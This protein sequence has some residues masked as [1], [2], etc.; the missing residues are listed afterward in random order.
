MLICTTNPHKVREFAGL[1]NPL[2][3]DLHPIMNLDIP[4]TGDSF[5]DNAREKAR[6]YALRY[7]GQWLLSEDS[8]LVVPAL[9]GMPGAFSARYADVQVDAGGVLR[10]ENSGRSRVEMDAL[11][12]L[13]LLREA[14]DLPQNN[15]GA[16]FVS[17][18][19]VVDPQGKIAFETERRAT[20]W[21][22]QEIRGS[23]GFGYDSIFRSDHSFG[24]TWAE[25]PP[26]R[27]A[28]FSHRAKATS[29]LMAWMCSTQR[30]LR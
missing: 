15:R 27:K 5:V 14:K 17:Y 12:I 9:G 7:P 20:G 1:L 28:L 30:E 23:G 29:D 3:I 19:V 2:G 11:N 25:I 24:R 26:D 4:E 6:G 13:R 22:T 21:I 18:I 8:G 10:I 16:Y